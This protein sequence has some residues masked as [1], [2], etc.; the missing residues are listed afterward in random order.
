MIDD[1]VRAWLTGHALPGRRIVEVRRL[2]G[3]FSNDT[4]LVRTGDDRYVLRRYLRGNASAVEVAL[5][6]RLREVLPVPEIIAAD[7]SGAVAGSPVVLSRF[8]EG[9]VGSELLAGLAPAEAERLGVA[10]GEVLARIG[11]VG[12]ATPGFFT[13]PELEPGPPGTEPASGLLAFVDR[14]LADGNAQSALTTSEVDGLRGLA[15]AWEPLLAAVHGS[16]RLVHSDFNPKNLLAARTGDGW[17]V[18]AV[19]DWEFAFSGSPL[20]DVGNML[21]FPEETGGPYADGFIAGYTAHTEL[22]DDWRE[23]S[24]ALDLYALAEFLTRPPDHPFFAKAVAVIREQLGT[25]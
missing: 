11:S 21:R 20:V 8:V 25:R 15:A 1:G 18:T 14:C 3:G 5:A 7:T 4:L 13:G 2:A 23:L 17:A 12:L 16:S 9:T 10:V 6:L 24:R 22:P 19:L